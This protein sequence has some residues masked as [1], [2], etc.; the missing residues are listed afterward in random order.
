M[1]KKEMR[2]KKGETEICDCGSEMDWLQLENGQKRY[3]CPECGKTKKG[4]ANGKC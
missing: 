4:N 3:T 1:K 2:L